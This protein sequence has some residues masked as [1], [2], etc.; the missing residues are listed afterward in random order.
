MSDT[1]P[2]D[3]QFRA[4]LRKIETL[5]R[6]QG[7]DEFRLA[8]MRMLRQLGFPVLA[9]EVLTMDVDRYLTPDEIAE[10]KRMP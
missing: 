10:R 7:H 1:I 3:K 8:A 5:Q 4:Q 9:R 6:Q 2:S